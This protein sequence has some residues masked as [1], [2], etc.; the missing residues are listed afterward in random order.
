MTIQAIETK[1]SQ[2]PK[3]VK[4]M[5]IL[6]GENPEREGLQ[7][8]P[9]R[10]A[11]SLMEL[12]SGYHVDLDSLINKAVFNEPYSEMVVV[13]DIRFYSLCEHHLLPFFG[14]RACRLYSKWKDNWSF[15]NSQN[16][17]CFCPAPAGTG[18][19]D[20]TGCRY[21]SEKIKTIGCWGGDGG[22]ASVYGDER[23]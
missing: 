6:L 20:P 4:D 12:T 10:V 16:G 7:R 21:H 17:G 13:K 14:D 3:I 5:L 15:E 18:A 9:S 8:T 1:V 11:R 2:L 22:P 23:G 19:L